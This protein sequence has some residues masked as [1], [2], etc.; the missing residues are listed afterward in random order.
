LNGVWKLI[1]KKKSLF[2]PAQVPGTVFE[3]LLDNKIIEDPFYGL[4]EHDMKWVYESDWIFQYEFDL[5][6][7]FLKHKNIIL[8]FNGIDTF[9][10][11]YLNDKLIGYTKNMFV[12]YDFNVK[13][14]LKKS[15][16]IL[17]I[18]IN[19]PTKRAGEEIKKHGVNL[20]T[21]LTYIPGIPYLR[22]AQYSFGWDWG[23][24]LP[25]IGIWQPV[26]LI[27]YDHIKIGSTYITQTFHYNLN[28]EEI[29][30]RDY[31]NKICVTDVEILIRIDLVADC[32]VT[33]LKDYK[34]CLELISPDGNK[35]IKEK[36]INSLNLTFNIN[37]NSP[38]L[39]W[40]HDLG[41]PDLYVLKIIIQQS[42]PIEIFKQKIGIRDLQLIQYSDKWGKSFFF[43]LNGIPIF[44]K[45]A[46]WVPID[47]FIPRG[48]KIGLYQ[49]ILR[50]AKK[51]HMNMIRV[52]GGGI[53]EDDVFY[54]LCDSLGI[55]V[56]QDFPFACAIYPSYEEF[57]ESIN[58]EF[59][60]NI[61]RLR[62]HP[63]LALWCGNNEVEWLWNWKLN[64]SKITEQEV[65]ND[66]KK[67]YITI[68]EVILP[69]LIAK[70]DPNRS[71]WPSSP[72]NGY[73]GERIGNIDSNSPNI[74]DSHFWEVWHRNKPF[75]AY[76]KFNSRFMSEFGFE[77]FPSIKTIREFCSPDQLD[78]FSPIMKNHQKNSAGNKK[79]MDYMK[80]RFLIPQKFEHQIIL[81][82]I[83][84][85]EAI[86]Y[87]VEHWRR[88]RND[89][90][91]MGALYWQLNDCWPVV[92]WS[93]LDYFGRWKALHYFAKR[94]FQPI[95]ASV[96]ENSKQIEFWVTNDLNLKNYI[97]L[98]WKIFRSDGILL[99]NGNYKVQVF[100]C[101]SLKLG[102]IDVSSINKDKKHE[103]NN[104]VFFKLKD[105]KNND[106]IIYNGF[107]L[108]SAPK[109][110]FLKDPRLL[111]S[112]KEIHKRKNNRIKLEIEIS[113]K[114]IALYVFIE[115]NI[116]DFVASDNYFSLE[117]KELR[118]I[119]IK[120][121]K[122]L[123]LNEIYSIEE[124]IN[125][126][127]V[128]SLYDILN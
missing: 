36:L 79:L 51:A 105:I 85:A 42:Q 57:L 23:P 1:N 37:I 106:K 104:M 76:R 52:W 35:I 80:K 69:K 45:G 32:K 7:E 10:S 3:A 102:I 126:L 91:C 119:T 123:N 92:S 60:Q 81:S 56:W 75:S 33:D 20:N 48:K 116:V 27:G 117:P 98:E 34:I 110:F 89:F 44:A 18:I 95:I 90:H 47:S 25:D 114:N 87:G 30:V 97:L 100:P 88:N 24:K 107:R 55:L 109:N 39:W 86:E 43:L 127:K 124:I 9:A 54:E 5:S 21:G 125:S 63:S 26:Q 8:C 120:I 112:I 67:G 19:S 72:S 15:Q 17:K 82:Q 78:F 13:N 108:F 29:N 41:N 77:S 73:V 40:T 4:N 122:I 65:I 83:T 28:P 12:R 128:R 121:E 50:Y 99:M 58:V 68:F 66:F 22:K 71:Y 53:Y 14:K 111:Y 49:L 115:S 74:G 113:A 59:T 62:N 6:A 94:L 96:K 11:V 118:K 84:Q 101:S 64:T 46:N 61:M 103:E 31:M 16:N 2:I 93:S 38:F 70:Y